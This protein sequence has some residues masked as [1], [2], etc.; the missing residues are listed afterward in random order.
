[1]LTTEK[2]KQAVSILKEYNVDLW[3][4]FARES[5]VN[6]D[7]MLDLILNTS[8]TWP[9]AFIISAVG[10]SIAI[11]GS[12]D[13]QNIRDHAPYKIIPYVDSMRGPL[14]DTLQRINPKTIAI[15]YSQSDV[16]SDGLT[17]GLFLMLSDY[18]KDSPYL[19]RLISSEDIVAALRGRKSS[20]EVRKIQDAICETLLIFDVLTKVIRTGMSEKQVAD[21]IKNEMMSRNLL[22]AWDPVHCPGVFTGPESAGAHAGPTDRTIIPGHILNIDFGVRKADYVSDLQ[23]TWYFCR[24]SE[25]TAPEA[26]FRG[27][28]T[29]VEAI[30]LASQSLKPGKKGWEIDHIA[31]TYIKDRGYEEYPHALGHQVGRQAHDGSA[32]L[33]PKW[34]RYKQAPYSKIESGQV[35]TLEPRLTVEGHGIATVEEIVLVEESGVRFLSDPQTE[36]IIV[37][38]RE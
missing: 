27:F 2:I 6:P 36:L 8:C 1:M 37:P 9:S 23:R 38:Y 19:T 3:I 10:D 5:A 18:L 21:I 15:N 26:V 7:P 30:Q 16:M 35:F 28:R 14:L 4:T 11:V 24:K 33:C 22:P 17:H 29:I 25:K 20:E 31:R 12:L 32:L 13:E 34:D